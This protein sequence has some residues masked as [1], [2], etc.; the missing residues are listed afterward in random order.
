MRRLTLVTTIVLMC[1]SALATKDYNPEWLDVQIT[2]QAHGATGQVRATKAPGDAGHQL[3]GLSLTYDNV[4]INLPDEILRRVV[5][6]HLE[7]LDIK[8]GQHFEAGV[9][10]AGSVVLQVGPPNLDDLP[11]VRYAKVFLSFDRTKFSAIR[12]DHPCGDGWCSTGSEEISCGSP[13]SFTFE[14][15]QPLGEMEALLRGFPVIPL[16]RPRV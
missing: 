13:L 14:V 5:D 2:F 16:S 11:T 15:Q 9:A 7:S 8:F 10:W 4:R 1:N 3:T 12:I 6:P